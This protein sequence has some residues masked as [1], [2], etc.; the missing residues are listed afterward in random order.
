MQIYADLPQHLENGDNVHIKEIW[1]PVIEFEGLYEISNFGRVKSIEKS[2]NNNGGLQYRKEKILKPHRNIHG[3]LQVDLSK[4][5]T[6]T[7]TIHR[8]VALAFIPNPMN[9][10]QVN[11]KDGNKINNFVDNLEWAT[12]SEN[13]LHSVR[14]L[15]KRPI[16]KPVLQ[17]K[18]NKVV[19]EFN[20]T[21]DAQRFT[22]ITSGNISNVCLGKTKTAGGYIW[23]YKNENI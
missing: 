20:S 6:F 21:R 23:R 10:A 8:M 14:V 19:A 4:N 16:G 17:I 5:K 2:V 11:H 1:R 12:P 15:G 3:Y 13:T 9:K 7:K 18:N 22:G